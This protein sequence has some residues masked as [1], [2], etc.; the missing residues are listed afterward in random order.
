MISV[1]VVNHDGRDHLRRC[2][3]SLA[4]ELREDHEV[5]V[6]DNASRDDSVTM[7][8]REFPWATLLAQDENLGFGAANNLAA[9]R[10]RGEYLLLLNS[11]AWLAGD[12]HRRLA[13]ALAGDPGLGAVA[14]EVRY[15]DGRLQFSWVPETGVL[16]EAA[17]MLRNR[18]EGRSWAHRRLPRLL[19]LLGPGWHSA[20][21]LMVRRV[22][23]EEV[24][25]FDEG[26]FLYFED[27]DLC[28]RLRDRGWRL[29][30]V[31]DA[32]AFHVK[33]GSMRGDRQE[34]EYRRGQLRY[35]LKHRPPWEVALLRRR[36]TAKARRAEEPLRSALLAL[37]AAP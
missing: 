34:V 33:G 24:R 17:Q 35:Y 26:F 4:G 12:A 19:R 30:A 13:G 8:R 29:A 23:W 7:V 37:L 18:F 3:D 21:C 31:A 32:V 20:S 1:L 15:P 28:R 6:V 5:I 11:D 10:A 22:A 36:L 27:V 14:P 9:A 25:G 16:G 2:L